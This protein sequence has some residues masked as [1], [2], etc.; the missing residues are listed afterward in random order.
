M[1]FL[2]VPGLCVLHPTDATPRLSHPIPGHLALLSC[3]TFS[4]LGG[5][6]WVSVGTLG[7]WRCQSLITLSAHPDMAVSSS[8]VLLS[9]WTVKNDDFLSVCHKEQEVRKQIKIRLLIFLLKTLQRALAVSKGV[10]AK[11]S[12]R[13]HFWQK[14]NFSLE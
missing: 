13:E 14:C 2:N 12:S 3:S 7:P 9:W 10:V 11:L 6:V 1:G 8:L 5:C 4:L